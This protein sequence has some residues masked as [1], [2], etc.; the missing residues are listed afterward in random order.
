MNAPLPILQGLRVVEAT[1]FVAAP[2]GGMT[3]AQLGADVIRIDALSGGLDAKR[4]PVTDDGH[5]NEVSLFWNGLNKHKRSVALD[6]ASPE[7]RELAMAIAT[8]PGDGA[9]LLV[10]NLPPRGWL[11]HEALRARRADLIQLTLSGVRSQFMRRR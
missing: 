4:W 2:L 9:G 11:A 7:G 6:L 3:L 8:A 10:T 1:A 5:G